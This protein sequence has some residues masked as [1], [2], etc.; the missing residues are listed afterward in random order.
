MSRQP[1]EMTNKALSRSGGMPGFSNGNAFDGIKLESFKKGICFIQ[2]H[3]YSYGGFNCNYFTDIIFNYDLDTSH[4]VYG[5]YGN[6]NTFMG[7][8]M[9]NWDQSRNIQRVYDLKTNDVKIYTDTWLEHSSFFSSL[10]T[11]N[12]L[13]TGCPSNQVEIRYDNTFYPLDYQKKGIQTSTGVFWEE[14]TDTTLQQAIDMMPSSGGKIFIN[15]PSTIFSSIHMKSNVQVDFLGYQII[16]QTTQP[17]FIF[18]SGTHHSTIKHTTIHQMQ[19]GEQNIIQ[20]HQA[21]DQKKDLIEHNTIAHIVMEGNGYTGISLTIQGQS[22]IWNNTFSDIHLYKSN[23]IVLE[24]LK[25]DGNEIYKGWANG[26]IFEYICNDDFYKGIRFDVPTSNLVTGGGFHCNLFKHILYQIEPM[27][28]QGIIDIQGEENTFMHVIYWDDIY[29]TMTYYFKIKT[30]AKNTKI[31]ADWDPRH[32]LN[33]GQETIIEEDRPY[34]DP[35]DYFW[36]ESFVLD[37]TQFFI[38]PWYSKIKSMLPMIY[39]W[40]GCIK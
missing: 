17:C 5:V 9:N 18:P 22:G 10:G 29:D 15:E 3:G 40:D 11:I 24:L 28:S 12:V 6:G 14:S 39:F 23:G 37:I 1:L 27:S 20:F 13:E 30:N 34:F 19:H 2:P 38:F 32:C 26:N 31:W 21:G 7:I 35:T 25:N 16:L 36:E 33:Y 8:S 4:G